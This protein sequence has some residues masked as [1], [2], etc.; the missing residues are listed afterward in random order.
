VF[1]RPPQEWRIV[2]DEWLKTLSSDEHAKYTGRFEEL[3]WRLDGNLY[4]RRTAGA[5]YRNEL[6]DIVCNVIKTEGFNFIRGVKD[7]CVYRCS[8]TRAVLVHHIDDCRMTAPPDVLERLV[9]S[10]EQYLEIKRGPL[11]VEDTS[12][13]VLGKTK[14]RTKDCFV[15]IPDRKHVTNMVAACQMEGAKASLV[16][17]KELDLAKKDPLS[18]TDASAYRSAVGSGIY[19]STDRRDSVCRKRA[20]ATHV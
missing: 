6:E 1:L 8:K 9:N 10:M 18:E 13:D 3:L 5:V 4:G 15:T 14:F 12:V 2:Y 11:E 16:P 19:L 7:P 17:S 20:C